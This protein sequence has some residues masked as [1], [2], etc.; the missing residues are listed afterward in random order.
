MMYGIIKESA[1]EK[2]KIHNIIF[3]KIIYNYMI[4][5]RETS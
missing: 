1:N 4:S 3:E 5:K 2:V